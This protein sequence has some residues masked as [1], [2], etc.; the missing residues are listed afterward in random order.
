MFRHICVKS[1]QVLLIKAYKEFTDVIVKSPLEFA[2]TLPSSLEPMEKS[3]RLKTRVC[4]AGMGL[5]ALLVIAGCSDPS[6][7]KPVSK[8]ESDSHIPN[9]AT[10]QGPGGMAKPGTM[11]GPPPGTPGAK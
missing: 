8:S 1:W 6:G 3:M 4:L 5:F 7:S 2:A 10:M 9:A 11:G